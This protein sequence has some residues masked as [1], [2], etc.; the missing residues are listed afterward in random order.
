MTPKLK[1][2]GLVSSPA[3]PELADLVL[4]PLL[5]QLKWAVSH[6]PNPDQMTRNIAEFTAEAEKGLAALAEGAVSAASDRMFQLCENC[7]HAVEVKVSAAPPA[8]EEK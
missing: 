7:G 4:K 3:R 6:D 2:E 8:L 1:L 5:V